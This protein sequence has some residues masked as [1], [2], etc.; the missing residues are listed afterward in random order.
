M[1]LVFAAILPR[2]DV[3]EKAEIIAH[4]LLSTSDFQRSEPG[5]QRCMARGRDPGFK[6]V[7]VFEVRQTFH[8]LQPGIRYTFAGEVQDL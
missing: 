3:R 7:Q 6:Q 1:P 4:G 8:V 2:L 5:F